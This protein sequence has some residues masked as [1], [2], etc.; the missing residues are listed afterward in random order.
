MTLKGEKNNETSMK[1]C[2]CNTNNTI[3]SLLGAS[4][5]SGI[6]LSNGQKRGL[7]TPKQN[8][9]STV[10]PKPM[11]PRDNSFLTD[12]NEIER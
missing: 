9:I 8:I 12:L 5:I 11:S 1:A 2:N 10:T 4:K 7:T 3:S 6:S